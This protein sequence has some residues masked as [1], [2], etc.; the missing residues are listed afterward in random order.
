MKAVPSL[1]LALVERERQL[2]SQEIAAH[3]AQTLL[4]ATDVLYAEPDA[5]AGVGQVLGICAEATGADLAV[6]LRL[7]PRGLWETRLST[8]LAFG[9]PSWDV[10]PAI[11]AR[12]RRLH[13]VTA[14]AHNVPELAR[15]HRSCLVTPVRVEGEPPMALVLFARE[16][17]R[18]S[19]HDRAL[20]VRIANALTRAIER[21]QLA[22]RN[23]VL[24]RIIDEGAA[25][26]TP[27]S[28]LDRS[29]DALSHVFARVASWQSQFARIKAEVL[30]ASSP[31]IEAV[32]E[33]A[34]AQIGAIAGFDR[35][36]VF[37]TREPGRVDNLLEWTGPGVACRKGQ[38]QD[39]PIEVLADWHA[40]L[41][42]GRPVAMHDV[43]ALPAASPLR[44]T[45]RDHGIQSLVIAPMMQDG[46]L[47]G[48]VCFENCHE[49]RRS[50]PVEVNLL[51]S[52]ANAFGAIFARTAA[53]RKAREATDELRRERDRLQATLSALPDLL[54]EVDETGRFTGYHF[55]A[56][57]RPIVPP[58]AFLGKLLEDVM[59]PDRANAY[60]AMMREVDAVGHSSGTAFDIQFGEEIRSYIISAGARQIAPDRRGYAFLLREVTDIRQRQQRILRLGKIAE[61]T[62][63]LVVVTDARGHIDW[64]NPAFERRTGWTLDEVRGCQPGELLH[65]DRADPE[66]LARIRQ[67]WDEHMPIQAE[68]INRARNGEDFWVSLDNQP[69]FDDRGRLA[70]YVS[71][72]TDITELKRAHQRASRVRLMAIESASDGIAIMEP[73]GKFSYMN[74][75]YRRMYGLRPGD[76]ITR[77]RGRDLVSPRTAEI[78]AAQS[79]R[80][81][82]KTG[83]W[84][85]EMLGEDRAGN[86]IHH[87]IT[88]TRT[89]RDGLLA[90]SRDISRRSRLE[91]ERDNLREELQRAQRRE[92][93]A[94]LSAGVAH[95]LNNLVAV[96][97][98][99]VSLLDQHFPTDPQ[100]FRAAL[101]RI[102]RAMDAARTL[103]EGLGH[104]GKPTSPRGTHDA[105]TLVREAIDLLGTERI[106][107]HGVR[108]T[109]PDSAQPV[110][111]NR[112]DLLQVI[113]NL[114]LN[115]CEASHAAASAAQVEVA[116]LPAGD[117]PP[118]RAPDVGSFR[119]DMPCT[120]LVV[121]DTG[122][123]VDPELRARIFDRYFTTK[124]QRGTG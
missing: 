28:F 48:F 113:V 15:A 60:R 37:R 22:Y 65:S 47:G 3:H 100:D 110:W 57:A 68:L 32:V 101:G 97:S 33:Q 7:T 70:G 29:F 108:A 52:V 58:E 40:D 114:A 84:H 88:L 124:G 75:S 38:L 49:A 1:F 93:L 53:E 45:M 73:D 66:V 8:D 50:L 67:A 121:A 51:Q 10:T 112:T 72:Q 31:C 43:A 115:A 98:G 102:S 9:F 17:A 12:P 99:T 117:P 76:N 111:A 39:L 103:V 79:Y 14:C 122:P 62:S 80:E 71:V 54:L 90:I 30:N 120:L 35:V 81:F 16:P 63:N 56:L 85:G 92:T 104:L 59:P 34:I 36:R 24:T 41:I 46:A 27:A 11:L 89:E 44:E 2:R 55:G 69:L 83:N 107:R 4:R 5:E 91:A 74:P 26:A 42:S 123:G 116:V 6:L 25:E 119:A 118:S 82:Q 61:L 109:L 77:L 23:A 20:T 106:R 94:H 105:R 86:P 96:V 64:V 21:T 19:R 78:F 18:F 87:E 13:D 95:D